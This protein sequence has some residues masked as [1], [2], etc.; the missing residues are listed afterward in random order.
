MSP[1]CPAMPQVTRGSPDALWEDRDAMVSPWGSQTGGGAGYDPD[2]SP[3]TCRTRWGHPGRRR[4]SLDRWP[5][6]GE[7]GGRTYHRGADDGCQ[8]DLHP[9]WPFPFHP[10]PRVAPRP[11]CGVE[12]KT[13]SSHGGSYRGCSWGGDR[14]ALEAQVVGPALRPAA[15]GVAS[16]TRPKLLESLFPHL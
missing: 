3:E 5:G 4:R 8:G 15:A 6:A 9:A 14:V 10:R 1:Q 16:G 13:T 2:G 7:G 12:P 11:K